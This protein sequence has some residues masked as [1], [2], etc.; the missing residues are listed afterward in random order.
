MQKKMK[1]KPI[2]KQKQKYLS[3]GETRSRWQQT[4]V[5]GAFNESEL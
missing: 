5:G 2:N 4:S 3:G 1:L